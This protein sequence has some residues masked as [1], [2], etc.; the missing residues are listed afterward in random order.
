MPPFPSLPSSIAMNNLRSPHYSSSSAP[1]IKPLRGLPFHHQFNPNPDRIPPVKFSIYYHKTSCKLRLRNLPPLS[2]AKKD[3]ASPSPHA[4]NRKLYVA[5]CSAVTVA[6]AIANRVL[7]KLALVPMKE[8]PFFLA[9]L[10]TFG[11]VAVYF[12]ALHMRYRAGIA[13]DE[14][15]AIPKWPFVFIGLLEALGVV[16]GMYSGAML[17]GPAIPILSQTFL[18]WQLAFSMFL[19]RRSYSLNRLAGCFLVAAGVVLAVTSGSE[20]N[21]ILSGVGILWPAMMIVSTAFQAVAS[22]LKESVFLDAATRFKGK[23][24]DIFVVNSFGSG[25]QALFVLLFLPFLSNLKGIP[26]SEL[27]SYLRSGAACF[28]HVGNKTT[29]C[30]GAP[31]LPI[32]YIITNIAFNISVLNL[33]KLSSAV[34]SSLAVMSSVPISIYILSL[35]LPYLPEGVNLSPYFVLGSL[36]LMVGLIVYNV[37]WPLKQNSDNE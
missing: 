29:G 14:M 31:L 9:Q 27:H 10:T 2:A 8:F 28:L 23:L 24:L 22:V 20:H 37:S 19:L 3:F 11:Y 15:L 35:P 26:L 6:L 13:T 7:Y 5:V 4:P 1:L 36:V 34:V 12:S 17:P 32:L 30:D 21:Q 18:V 33:L 16:S 25:F